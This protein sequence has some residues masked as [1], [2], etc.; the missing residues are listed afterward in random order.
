LATRERMSGR[1]EQIGFDVVASQAN[2]VWCTHREEPLQPL[3]EHLKSNQVLVRYIQYPDW[4][5]GL[6][7][8]VG[9]DPQVDACLDL[10]EARVSS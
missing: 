6:R 10:L 9:T 1:L 4:G 7:I 3:Y 5:D 8:S 2:F